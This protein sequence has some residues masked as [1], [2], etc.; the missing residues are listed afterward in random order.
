M[1]L[2]KDKYIIIEE[3]GSG[4]FGEVYKGKIVNT[5]TE[6]AIKVENINKTKRI[7]YEYKIYEDLKKA[8][9][10][11][12]IPDIY[13]FVIT[14]KY[15]FMCMQILGES[16]DELFNQCNNIF[17]IETILTLG[18]EIIQELQQIHKIG[19]IHRDIKPSNFLV[20]KND[21]SKIYIMDFGLAKKYIINNSHIP[22]KEGRSL[23]GTVRYS[24]INMH[25]GLEPTRRDDLESVG[26]M[27]IYFAIKKLP[28]Q[29]LKKQ[30]GIT[31]I[32]LIGEVK[33]CTNINILCANLPD[34][35][36]DYII[37]IRSVGFD[38]EPNYN[39][40]INLLKKYKKINENFTYDWITQ[41]SSSLIST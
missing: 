14:P 18:I 17:S 5:N 4:S 24:S 26:Y 30:K 37:Y 11:N 41:K 12:I 34:C 28:W 21:K 1:K 25:L 9:I 27:L 39:Y 20:G 31:H 13:D 32:D 29:G 3:I 22:F 23:I 15:H 19:Y 16:L 33:M 36:K 10:V 35:F 40:L 7:E 2:L 38:E 8:G 6:I